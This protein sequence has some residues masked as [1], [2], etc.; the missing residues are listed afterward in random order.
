MASLSIILQATHS[1]HMY[2]QNTSL[3]VYVL[4]NEPACQKL[5]GEKNWKKIIWWS[6]SCCENPFGSRSFGEQSRP[7]FNIIPAN[8]GMHSLI[9]N[10][11]ND[12][13]HAACGSGSAPVS[14]DSV[15][16]QNKL[17]PLSYQVVKV[18]VMAQDLPSLLEEVKR[19]KRHYVWLLISKHNPG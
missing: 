12:S 5:W 4:R 16:C 17:E 7:Y 9:Y 6:S 18:A 13:V 2:A 10:R 19:H 15:C 11:V 3:T 1:Q 8:S 14:I